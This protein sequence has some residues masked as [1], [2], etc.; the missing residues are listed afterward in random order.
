VVFS[1]FN[2]DQALDKVDFTNLRQR[3][4]QN[5]VQEKLTKQWIDRTLRQIGK[6]LPLA[7]E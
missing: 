3:L 4:N 5:T 2:Q 1:C 7:A 6:R